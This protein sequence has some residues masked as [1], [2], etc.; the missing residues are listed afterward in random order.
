M[1]HNIDSLLS[2]IT[3]IISQH[4]HFRL[5]SQ[6][7]YRW[8]LHCTDDYDAHAHHASEGVCWK[9]M[10]TQFFVMLQ[11]RYE[12]EKA[13][14]EKSGGAGEA[15]AAPKK[16]KAAPKKPAKKKEP[17]PEEDDDDDEE[18]L[19]GSCHLLFSW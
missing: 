17:E 9:V 12:K 8:V 6:V 10:T 11:A 18:V 2:A 14:Y 16:A 5:H 13:A 1:C 3:L 15:S 7:Q 19:P 4:H